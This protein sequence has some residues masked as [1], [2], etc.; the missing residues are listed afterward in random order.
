MNLRNGIVRLRLTKEIYRVH[1]MCRQTMTE[2]FFLYSYDQPLA[3]RQ[4]GDLFWLLDSVEQISLPAF[5]ESMKGDDC[6]SYHRIT[7]SRSREGFACDQG[8]SQWNHHFGHCADIDPRVFG[9]R[10]A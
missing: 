6:Y 8:R 4:S 2:V 7:P 5:H 10:F 1:P 3:V 9:E